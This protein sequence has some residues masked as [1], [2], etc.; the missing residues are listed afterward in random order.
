MTTD[1]RER[2]MHPDLEWLARNVGEWPT[3]PMRDSH[4][5]GWNGLNRDGQEPDFIRRAYSLSDE[6][7][8]AQW[9]QARK[10]LGLDDGM[11]R[12][13]TEAETLAL[14]GWKV[15]DILQGD[16]GNGPDRILITAIG[17]DLFTC[18]WD[19]KCTGEYHRESGSTTLSCRE[20]RK[21]G[22][23]AGLG[24]P[25]NTC[26][27]EEEEAWQAKERQLIGS[28]RTAESFLHQAAEL[29]AER[30][31]QY[32][33]PGGERSMGKAVAALNAITGRD[34]TEAEGWLLMSLVKRVRQHSGAGY[35]Q[36]SA[37]DA[38]AYAALEAEALESAG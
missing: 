5:I 35:H 7:T 38:V 29:M 1:A 27:P 2:D 30:G 31:K 15:G 19:Y 24:N 23:R 10:E 16:E 28:P 13:K 8:K 9:L 14:N 26:I 12:G 33:Q 17:E 6:Y 37:E 4:S 3:K 11:K 20:W 25:D 34:L 18:K 21:V 36:D 22:H 32:D